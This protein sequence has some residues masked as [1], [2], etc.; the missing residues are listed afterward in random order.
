MSLTTTSYAKYVDNVE[1][2]VLDQLEDNKPSLVRSLFTSVPWQEGDG[3][4]VT[5]NSIALSGYAQ[6]VDENEEYPEINP[7]DGNE[8]SKYQIQ[9]GDKL[10]ISRR[11]MKFG[12][13]TPQILRFGSKLAERVRNS[14]DLEL[15]Q[16]C[17]AEADNTTF[18]PKGKAAYNIA[19]SDAQPLFSASHSYGGIT[20]SNI[21]S[22]GGTLNIANFT[23]AVDNMCKNTPDDFG[24]Y[25]TPSPDTVLIAND[26]NMIVKAHQMFGSALTPE[27]NNNAVN[28]YGGTGGYKVIA[29]KE[30]AKN[31]IGTIT[32]DNIYRWVILDSNMIKESWQLMMAE[33]PT[34]EQKFVDSDN[35]IAKLLVTQFAAYAIVQ[36]QGAYASLS[37]T[38]PT[39]S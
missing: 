1:R 39:L 28:F 11:M 19:T 35:L 3:E 21:L 14:L 8:L 24:T 12:N 26:Q 29:L 20:F 27:S 37:T 32:T 13:R 10:N 25:I 16:Q 33:E 9:Y 38:K 30:G 2:V 36:P 4:K 17:F 23:T 6:R 22:G 18:T 7:T 15:V 5:F 34:T 31:P